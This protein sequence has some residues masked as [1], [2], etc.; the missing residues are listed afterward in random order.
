MK[1]KRLLQ[2]IGGMCLAALIVLPFAVGGGS[3]VQASPSEY[4]PPSKVTKWVFQPMFHPGD[5]GWEF[6]IVPWI[7][8][9]KKATRGT[10]TFD[11]LP[12][13]SITSGAEAFG[14][15]AKG[16]IDVT[17]GWATVYGGV[18]PEGFLAYGMSFGALNWEEAW[19]AMWAD[20]KYKIGDIVQSAAHKKN[21]HWGG[22]TCQG[23]NVAYTKFPVAKWE[24]F[25]GRKMRAGGPHALFHKAM[26]GVPVAMPVG[27]IY[28]AIKL[29]TIEG[30]YY[31]IASLEKM[32][33]HEVVTH[34]ILPPW[35]SA[36]HQ[37]IFINLDKWNALNQ[38]Q[39]DRIMYDV[40]MPTY[41]ETSRLHFESGKKG[42]DTFVKAGGKI[43]TLSS[44][45]VVRMR[46]RVVSEVWPEVAKLSPET[47]RGVEIWKT[48]LAD[49]GRL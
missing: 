28:M 23:N 5:A 2:L 42:L 26:G 41:F 16:T 43:V 19:A 21:V 39:K 12:V 3:P 20:P 7:E 33:F 31:D 47:A 13:G 18:L 29:G 36:Q 6:G 32:K 30:S 37:E 17:A 34:I 9:V 25:R 10:V 14:A 35:N 22:W 38:W 46:T 44:E 11:L 27:E 40:F 15:V 48:F 4:G 49:K 1:R 8:A 24:D 45:E